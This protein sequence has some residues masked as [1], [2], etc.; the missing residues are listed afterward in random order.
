MPAQSWSRG[1]LFL[2]KVNTVKMNNTKTYEDD[3][4]TGGLLIKV[5]YYINTNEI[6]SELSHENISLQ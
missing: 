6:P 1:I 3:Y 4:Y 5:A 2:D